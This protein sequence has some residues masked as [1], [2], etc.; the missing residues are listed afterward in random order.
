MYGF[1]FPVNVPVPGKFRIPALAPVSKSPE[2]AFTVP[3]DAILSCCAAPAAN[4]PLVKLNV[5]TVVPVV[6][7][8]T[9]LFEAAPVFAMESAPVIVDGR[10]FPVT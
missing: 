8:V 7:S 2:V 5:V 1:E 4:N 10:P 6:E 3:P 9:V